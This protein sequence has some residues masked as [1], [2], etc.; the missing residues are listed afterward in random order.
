MGVVYHAKMFI[1]CEIPIEDTRTTVSE[2]I[3]EN[4]NRYDTRTGKVSSVERVCVKEPVYK[5]DLGKKFSDDAYSLEGKH[6]D[7][8]EC[9]HYQGIFY[10]G[11]FLEEEGDYGF[12]SPEDELS[13]SEIQEIFSAVTSEM[14][15]MSVDTAKYPV[16][17]RMFKTVW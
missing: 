5:Y 15:E 11:Y 12:Y 3:Y 2:A 13:L 4:Q 1:G 6:S 7:I 14:E 9:V 10:V 17:M 16:K 8:I